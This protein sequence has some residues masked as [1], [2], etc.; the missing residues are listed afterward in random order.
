MNGKCQLEFTEPKTHFQIVRFVQ[1]DTIMQSKF[2]IKAS[3][4]K[5]DWNV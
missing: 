5:N 2:S 4:K 1:S 3:N